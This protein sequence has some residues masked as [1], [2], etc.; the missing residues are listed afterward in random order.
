MRLLRT[1]RTL[2]AESTMALCLVGALLCACSSAP[3]YEPE[4][5]V[6]QTP[7]DAA[8]PPPDLLT[9]DFALCSPPRP[10]P[11]DPDADSDGDGVRDGVDNC[12]AIKNP[13]QVDRDQD[14][15]G[16]VCDQAPNVYDPC[17]GTRSLLDIAATTNLQPGQR[18]Q[19]SALNQVNRVSLPAGAVAGQATL[20]LVWERPEVANI[21][22]QARANSS[23]PTWSALTS[24]DL[25]LGP[26]H[27]VP[28][29][30]GSPAQVRLILPIRSLSNYAF[31]YRQLRALVREVDGSLSTLNDC[32]STEEAPRSDGRCVLPSVVPC[33]EGATCVRSDLQV[34]L[35]LTSL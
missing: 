9:P 4:G 32:R 33:S 10:A 1:S 25:Q 21:Q 3:R 18:L 29:A 16:D 26:R 5:P 24:Y 19:M 27:P 34:E 28:L 8:T 20:T 13:D 14:R 2:H 23:E 6:E 31:R 15:L 30:P 7:P 17:A 35:A 12:P 22:V 11:V